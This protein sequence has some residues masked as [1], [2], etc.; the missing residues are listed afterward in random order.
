MSLRLRF[1][2]YLILAFFRSRVGLLDSSS[3]WLR[4]LPDDVDIRRL[5]DDRYLAYM[6]LG[7]NDLLVRLGLARTAAAGGTRTYSIVDPGAQA[8][9]NWSRSASTTFLRT[10][11]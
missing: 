3:I 7:R 2:V 4:A 5:A 8:R 11:S 6:N 1:V 10:A 9:S